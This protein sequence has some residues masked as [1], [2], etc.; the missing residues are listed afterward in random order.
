MKP[1][2]IGATQASELVA[3]ELEFHPALNRAASSA[4]PL[5]LPAL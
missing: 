4:P 5:V 2:P 1:S 3:D